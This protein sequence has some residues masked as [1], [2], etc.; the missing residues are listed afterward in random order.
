[1]PGRKRQLPFSCLEKKPLEGVIARSKPPEDESNWYTGPSS[2]CRIWISMKCCF[3]KAGGWHELKRGEF[4][5][6]P[7]PLGWTLNLLSMSC[8]ANGLQQERLQWH[9][10]RVNCWAWTE[11]LFDSGPGLKLCEETPQVSK[12]L[13][14]SVL[15]RIHFTTSWR[16]QLQPSISSCHSKH[17][18][19]ARCDAVTR[20]HHPDAPAVGIDKTNWGTPVASLSSETACQQWGPGPGWNHNRGNKDISHGTSKCLFSLKWPL[21][22]RPTDLFLSVF[23]HLCDHLLWTLRKSY[24]SICRPCRCM[25]RYTSTARIPEV[26]VDDLYCEPC[27]ASILKYCLCHT[28]ASGVWVD[29]ACVPF[30]GLK[31]RQPQD[32]WL[33]LRKIILNSWLMNYSQRILI[34][35]SRTKKTW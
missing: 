35:I 5:P 17:H 16:C 9:P 12:S 19:P 30:S 33:N 13:R 26:S 32:S 22:T 3:F 2:F 24:C 6:N 21:Q 23:I 34:A 27:T 15:E 28:C 14:I 18:A 20:L 7:Y 11:S 4:A 8:P 10:G 25:Q 1:M 31:G 29:V